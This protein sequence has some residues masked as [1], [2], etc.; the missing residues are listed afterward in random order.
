MKITMKQINKIAKD[1]LTEHYLGMSED[2]IKSE[3]LELIKD[4][5]IKIILESLGLEKSWNNEINVR[6]SGSFAD[7]AK[8]LGEQT[9]QKTAKDIWTQIIGDIKIEL[10]ETQK[11]AL[12]RIYKEYYIR[13]AESQIKEMAEEQALIDAPELFR[14]FL[15]QQEKADNEQN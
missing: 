9:L 8:I 7:V 13:T 10:T 11:K 4:Q 1:V 6:Y 12:Q 14:N 15:E 5:E 2:S 3:M